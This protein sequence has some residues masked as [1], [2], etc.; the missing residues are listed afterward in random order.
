MS[1]ANMEV[2]ALS[3]P[4][5]P[6]YSP[7]EQPPPY[8]VLDRHISV[9]PDARIEEAQVQQLFQVALG[10]AL[11]LL[12]AILHAETATAMLKHPQPAAQC[13]IAI[14]WFT[15]CDLLTILML[16]L[17]V[18]C[19]S[20]LASKQE[21]GY[22]PRPLT[23]HGINWLLAFGPVLKFACVGSFATGLWHFWMC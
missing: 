21:R 2:S 22:K 15:V 6:A 1:L 12:V 3:H 9:T 17:S 23:E 19:A 11:F 5:P 10:I 16:A 18:L 8:S 20:L 13:S 4:S 7:Y 14:N